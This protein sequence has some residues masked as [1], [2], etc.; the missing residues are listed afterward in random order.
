MANIIVVEDDPDLCRSV[1]RYLSLVGMN[2]ISAGSGAELDALLPVFTPDLLVLDVNLPDEDGFSIAARLR[3]STKIRIVMM[4]ARSK[5]DDRVL[6]LVAGADAY[7]VKPVDF[8]ELEAT[9][10]SLMRRLK[11]AAPARQEDHDDGQQAWSFDAANWS[12]ITPNGQV[13]PLTS[14][15]Y[16]VL[17][18]LTADPGAPIPREGIAIA[19]G[20]KVGSYDDRSIDAIMARLRRKVQSISGES[21]PIRA[22]RA[23]GYVFAAPVVSMPMPD[24]G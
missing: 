22:A 6:G 8:R 12:L 13:V 16:R 5:L 18:T 24:R 7:L 21:L 15:E 11:I 3:A 23:V 19:L 10:H 14:A 1:V 9:I 20:K 2:V 17:Q 4:T